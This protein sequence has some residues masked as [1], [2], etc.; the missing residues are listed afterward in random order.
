MPVYPCKNQINKNL[1]DLENPDVVDHEGLR[2]NRRFVRVAWPDSSNGQVHEEELREPESLKCC[3]GV[4]N[5][6]EELVIDKPF[7]GIFLPD[8]GE[9]MKFIMEALTAGK[10][11]ETCNILVP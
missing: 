5:L 2:E 8:D 11:E 7:Y 3:L 9:N 6:V 10:G 1:I 4:I